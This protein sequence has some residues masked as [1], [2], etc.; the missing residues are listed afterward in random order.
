MS[1][2]SYL[3]RSAYVIA[4]ILTR[5]FCCFLDFATADLTLCFQQQFHQSS[6]EIDTEYHLDIVKILREILTTSLKK[7]LTLCQ[8]Q[9]EKKQ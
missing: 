5:F 4:V 8:G 9:A 3:Y 6:R 1:L 2:T 7:Q